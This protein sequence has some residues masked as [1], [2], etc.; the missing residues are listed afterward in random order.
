MTI[1]A[2][3]QSPLPADWIV[4]EW[5]GPPAV[6]A[7]FTTRRSGVQDA[8]SAA[9]MDLGPASLSPE[10]RAGLLGDHRRRLRALLPADPVW[11][12]QVHG[13]GVAVI[14][15]GNRQRM[16]QDPPV[17]DAAVTRTPHIPLVVRTADCLP[18]LLA[19]RAGTVLAVAHAGWRGLAKGVLEA[20]V[21]AMAEAP[22]NIV[23][24]LGPAIG[25]DAFE[26]GA[27]V[28][29]AYCGPDPG[30]ASLFAPQRDG[31]WLADLPGLARRRL[32]R[33]GIRDVS[34]GTW[35]TYSDSARFFSWRRDRQMARMG[36]IAWIEPS[37]P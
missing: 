28:H 24:W 19:D 7:F 29:A 14:D 25:A 36:L 9:S 5:N 17:A 12:S 32:T 37:P 26:V 33:L 1:T 8:S 4:P 16:V 6:S 23:A 27:D 11:L 10:E 13:S 22:A 2:D 30:A 20:T 34:G 35:C 3:S 15:A 31:K 18:V 21:S